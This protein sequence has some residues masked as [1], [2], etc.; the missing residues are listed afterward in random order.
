M[1]IQLAGC[2]IAGEGNT[3]YLLHRNKK[4]VTQWELPGGKVETGESFEQTA[5]RELAEELGV[6]VKI[7][8]KL[9]G[10]SFTENDLEFEYTW[11]VA[12]IES[13]ELSIQEPNNFDDLRS[14]SIAELADLELSNNMKKLYESIKAKK[15]TL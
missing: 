4:G 14:F 6:Q 10:T 13:G 9:G 12:S 8:R 11:F 2:V 15:V 7:D 1:S 5:I 3:I